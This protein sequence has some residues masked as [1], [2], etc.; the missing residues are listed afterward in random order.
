MPRDNRRPCL[1]G[2]LIAGVT[3]VAYL[4]PQVMA[5]ACPRHVNTD[6]GVACRQGVK[7]HAPLTYAT[8]A[9]VPP[10][11]DLWTALPALVIYAVLGSSSSLSMGPEATTG[12]MTG[13][14]I[15]SLASGDP[16]WYAGLAATFALLVGAT[17]VGAWLLRL[18][19]IVGQAVAPV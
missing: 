6:P 12:L 4:I 14:A 16:A 8:V 7:I 19:F 18:G 9:G 15:G 5:Y 3:V 2:D 13:I 17:S 11:A 10:V 1:R